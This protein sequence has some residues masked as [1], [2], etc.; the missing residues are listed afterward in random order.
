[1]IYNKIMYEGRVLIDLTGDTVTEKD[2]RSGITAHDRHGENITGTMPD[3][4]GFSGEIKTKD[5]K[6]V[7]PEGY[8]SGDEY[9]KLED[10]A[11][12]FLTPDN[13]KLGVE[14]LGIEGTNVGDA[15]YTEMVNSAG[16]RTVI[17]GRIT[18]EMINNGSSIT[19]TG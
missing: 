3:N 2:L 6:F 1:M 16:G 10:N 7:L 12:R 17:I 14:I 11:I 15:F 18:E 9:V 8:Y 5:E 13:V 4:S 19:I